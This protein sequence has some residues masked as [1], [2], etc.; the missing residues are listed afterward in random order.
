MC[1]FIVCGFFW[2]V[3][4]VGGGG[5]EAGSEKGGYQVCL[6]LL[7]D[8]PKLSEHDYVFCIIFFFNSF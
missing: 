6:V 8:L 7:D 4:G 5:W 1:G 2:G 3:G